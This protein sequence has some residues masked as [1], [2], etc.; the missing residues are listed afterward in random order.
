[1]TTGTA[2]QRRN[3]SGGRAPTSAAFPRKETE[4][5]ATVSAQGYFTHQD[6]APDLVSIGSVI[7][8]VG[9]DYHA[10]LEIIADT[11][12]AWG[13]KV[14]SVSNSSLLTPDQAAALYANLPISG[15]IIPAGATVRVNGIDYIN[16]ATGPLPLP[17]TLPDANFV[18]APVP[19]ITPEEKEI[20]DA[21]LPENGDTV[22]S[23]AVFIR[24]G[25]QYI[26]NTGAPWVIPATWPATPVADIERYN[27]DVT[28]F[29]TIADA[30][31]AD[32][33]SPAITINGRTFVS[34][35]TTGHTEDEA[36]EDYSFVDAMGRLYVDS[37]QSSQQQTQKI[38][39]A[40][41]FQP[42]ANPDAQPQRDQVAKHREILSRMNTNHP[43]VDLMFFAGDL[44]DR[45]FP[46]D[47]E[48][49][50]NTEDWYTP[51]DFWNDAVD[52][53]I[54]VQNIFTISGNHDSDYRSRAE[55]RG[56]MLE[57]FLNVYPRINYHVIF[58]NIL[59]IFMGD[60]FRNTSGA[61]SDSTVEWWEAL[62]L[63]YASYNIV[64][65]T[66]QSLDGTI[67][68]DNINPDNRIVESNRFTDAM[69]RADNPVNIDL[70]IS[71][72]HA[73]SQVEFEDHRTAVAHGGTT[74]INC[75]IHI[76]SVLE[77]AV[78]RPSTY[79]TMHYTQGSSSVDLRHFNSDTESYIDDQ[80]VAVQFKAPIDV[81]N[82]P[83]FDGR[84]QHDA[85]NGI[86]YGTQ[87]TV[88]DTFEDRDLV[89]GNTQ[90]PAIVW[91]D[92]YQLRDAVGLGLFAGW[93]TGTLG[94]IPGGLIDGDAGLRDYGFGG[95]WYTVKVDEADE[96]Y[97]S[98][99]IIFA[100]TEAQDESSQV[101]VIRAFS[102]GS[103]SIKEGLR[104]D[105][106]SDWV[107][108]DA[109]NAPT[110]GTDFLHNLGT[111]FL[112]VTVL[113]RASATATRIYDWGGSSPVA[114]MDRYDGQ[115]SFKDANNITIGVGNTGV[116]AVDN[117][118][119]AA[120]Q[121]F[122][123]GQFRVIAWKIPGIT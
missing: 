118:D 8:V 24:D 73:T 20:F 106:V 95:G 100:S 80:A 13:T 22:A 55:G 67:D 85:M 122:I 9:E 78:Q 112:K 115:L 45:G 4:D 105:Y 69:T 76:P 25:V 74:F 12:A 72:H 61:I 62:C 19:L 38:L 96:V 28:D 2:L 64:C 117:T 65:I 71:G 86:Q 47:A 43:D 58:G 92:V 57:P 52:L 88:L 93:G 10:F 1:M 49:A 120:T 103:A 60:D 16:S 110:D 79:W 121:N 99:T 89:N 27:P 7:E 123:S 40:A 116:F 113:F 18:A 41:D 30:L 11:G 59:Y 32:V 36:L 66:H 75:G 104:P 5:F 94:Q 81:S 68:A 26:N 39:L 35:L 70:W 56:A 34:D 109:A 33:I 111:Q 108:I 54:P 14:I 114:E 6:I 21:N 84:Y 29:L 50:A 119:G 98:D 48:L 83:T 63:K 37:I 77:A 53:N 97:T 87:L 82:T 42:D 51:Q 23:G 44:W 17:V 3:Y 15:A 31:A 91:G 46:D 107:D 101:D 90:I 102:D